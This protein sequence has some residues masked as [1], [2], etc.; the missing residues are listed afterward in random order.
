MAFTT[1][2]TIIEQIKAGDDIAWQDFEKAYRGLIILRGRDRSLDNSELPDLVQDVMLSL[3]KY[4]SVFKYESSKGR[5]RDYLK[6][7]IDRAAF[8]MIRKRSN[9]L[10][11]IQAVS[12]RIKSMENYHDTMEKKWEDEWRAV[13]VDEALTKVRSEVNEATYEAFVMLMVDGIS[14]ELVADSLGIS[15]ESIYVAKHRVLKRLKYAVMNLEDT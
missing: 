15:K 13:I 3:F 11:K 6:Q 9:D 10:R 2:K 4:E 7:I 14:A 12:D 5:F 8:K 1:R